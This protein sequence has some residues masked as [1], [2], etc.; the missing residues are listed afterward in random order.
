[1][2]APAAQTAQGACR[3]ERVSDIARMSVLE[4]EWGRLA[5][6]AAQPNVF[7]DPAFALPA[8]RHLEAGRALEWLLV[9]QG[10]PP[11]EEGGEGRLIGALPLAKEPIG[12]GLPLKVLKAWT[13]AQAP[14]STPLLLAGEEAAAAEALAGALARGVGGARFFVQ[15]LA[16]EGAAQAAL[17]RALDGEHMRFSR[18]AMHDRAA[19]GEAT[20]GDAY[21]R[22][23]MGK[24]RFKEMRRLLAR[25]DDE[26][27]AEFSLA[28]VPGEVEAAGEAFLALEASGWKGRRGT[29]LIQDPQSAA[30][31]R[32]A[33]AG[34]SQK[35]AAWVVRLH[36]G[37]ICAAAAVVLFSGVRAWFWKVAYD[38]ALSRF[39]PGV[40][41]ACEVTRQLLARPDIELTDSCAVAGHPMIDHIWRQRIG[42]ADRLVCLGPGVPP[43][44]AVLAAERGR[45]AALGAAKNTLH[46]WRGH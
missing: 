45:L 27:R 22:Q 2:G 19:L 7:Y 3:V 11:A 41:L 26:G 39:S 21:L 20:G 33:L 43:F 24:K 8:W 36:A 17:D 38:E 25:L 6:G 12:R 16:A 44:S 4:G 1:M 10:P 18:L 14:L 9:W 37:G 23:S 35:R 28:Q 30:F 46:R 34:L 31:F 40:L 15:R 5:A 32:E 42:M 13:H 29:A